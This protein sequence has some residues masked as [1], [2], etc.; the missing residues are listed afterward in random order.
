MTELPPEAN[1]IIGLLL[2]IVFIVVVIF[3]IIYLPVY[4][5]Q[6]KLLL[7][8][9]ETRK[10]TFS[11]LDEP[12]NPPDGSIYKKHIVESNERQRYL[13]KGSILLKFTALNCL[14]EVIFRPGTGE[15][16]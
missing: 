8:Q 1:L 4:R 10:G 11:I 6:K 7:K 9:S 12:I 14:V 3:C 16:Q 5:I 13:P 15:M 2:L